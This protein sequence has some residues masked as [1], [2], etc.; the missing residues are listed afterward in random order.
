M[1]YEDYLSCTRVSEQ[2]NTLALLYDC[3]PESRKENV[4]K[5]AARAK[6]GKYFFGAP[7]FRAVGEPEKNAVRDGIVMTG[8]P[9]F[10]FF[11]LG[12]LFKYQ[13]PE[14]ALKIMLKEWGNMLEK[15]INTCWETMEMEGTMYTRSICHAWSAAPSIYLTENVLG[16]KP[17]EPGYRKFTV[18]PTLC[19]LAWA[20]GS[21]A[22][23]YGIIYVKAE[24]K[25]DGSCAVA[26]Q[27]PNECV[28]E[29][30]RSRK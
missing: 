25:E 29:K 26:G 6:D 10:L 17:L 12:T 9:F 3:V 24:K 1:N 30:T 19:D 8:S 13:M 2:T 15:G 21:V 27:A 18:N 7:A 11:T 22:T 4:I 5:I 16:I 28:W 23:P 20:Q 14:T